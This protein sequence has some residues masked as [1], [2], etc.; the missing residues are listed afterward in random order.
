LY[1]L[2]L[3]LTDKPPIVG[4]VGSL[5]SIAVLSRRLHDFDRS[6]WWAFV[7]VIALPLAVALPIMWATDEQTAAIWASPILPLALI[8]VG[9]PAGSI[10]DN[11]Y[12]SPPPFTVQR[13]LTGR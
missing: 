1:G 9:I 2:G 4:L 8:I 3:V 12:G 5:V 10:G 6:G 11:R 13:V 7:A